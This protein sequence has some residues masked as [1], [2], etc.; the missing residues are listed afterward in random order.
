MAVD[1]TLIGVQPED[2][3]KPAQVGD[4]KR[5]TV[6]IWEV[7]EREILVAVENQAGV[8]V[9]LARYT[10]R[11]QPAGEL[12]YYTHLGAG[13]E[14][15]LFHYQQQHQMPYHFVDRACWQKQKPMPNY[16]Y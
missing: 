11:L 7:L 15:F 6:M 13:A 2:P 12:N 14:N 3:Q 10:L 8:G 16:Y 5:V 1:E 9:R 4:E